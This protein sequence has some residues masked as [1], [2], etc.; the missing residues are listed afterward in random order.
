MLILERHSGESIHINDDI[1]LTI[2]YNKGNQIK[3]GVDAPRSV[4]IMRQE[5]F[6]SHEQSIEQKQ[7]ET[8]PPDQEKTKQENNSKKPTV[9]IKNRR[10]RRIV[11]PEE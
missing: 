5:L 7:A 10:K 6:D 8:P 9:T 3:M 4:S 11:L 1:K 2:Y